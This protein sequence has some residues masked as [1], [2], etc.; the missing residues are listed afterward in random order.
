M[1]VV[2]FAAF[3]RTKAA[4]CR[5]S[6]ATKCKDASAPA[7]SNLAASGRLASPWLP[8]AAS[9][10]MLPLFLLANLATGAVN[11]GMDTLVAPDWLA[12]VIVSGYIMFVA[13]AAAGLDFVISYMHTDNR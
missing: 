4:V 10:H 7:L 11:V 5:H 9:R 2:W 3:S 8:A 1:K 6:K 13:A 12:R